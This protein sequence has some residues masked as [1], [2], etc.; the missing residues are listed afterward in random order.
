DSR[1]GRI[2]GH[3]RIDAAG[4]RSRCG[5]TEQVA[6]GAESRRQHGATRGNPDDCLYARVT[7]TSRSGSSAMTDAIRKRHYSAWSLFREGLRGQRGWTPAWRD[8][9]PLPEYDVVVIASGGHVLA[10]AYY[11]AKQHGV[12]RVALLEKGW[13]GG[14]NTGRNTTIIRSNYFYSQSAALYDTPLSLYEGLNRA[15]ESRL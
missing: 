13:I 15:L 8:R 1:V 6:G 2:L 12:N 10:T 11:R 7:P 3:A 5:R 4:L 9:D 14:G